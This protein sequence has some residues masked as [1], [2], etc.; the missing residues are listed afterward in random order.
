MGCWNST[1]L[2]SG[3]S[4]EEGDRVVLFPFAS[5]NQLCMIPFRGSYND[6]GCITNIDA[7]PL[8][9]ELINE[10]NA[11]CINESDQAEYLKWSDE[12]L[13]AISR[14]KYLA[15][16]EV[17]GR[18]RTDEERLEYNKAWRT[19]P[20]K[21]IVITRKGNDPFTVETFL[22]QIER[23]HVSYYDMYEEK[24]KGVAFALVREEVWDKMV[25]LLDED[26]ASHNK[27]GMYFESL[28]EIIDKKKTAI[29]NDI[30]EKFSDV[31]EVSEE[32]EEN[33]TASELILNMK[34]MTANNILYGSVNDFT[35]IFH[36]NKKRI[37]SPELFDPYMIAYKEKY[38]LVILTSYL[39]IT[40]ESD[41][42]KGSQFNNHKLMQRAYE[43]FKESISIRD[44]QY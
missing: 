23:G 8:H 18:S 22:K 20:Q 39:R 7:N 44:E 37:T 1:C 32:Q 25:S 41:P 13:V 34:I 36:L 29:L 21:K 24:F 43:I 5:Y 31:D 40:I 33:A 12:E 6:Y 2:L 17:N 15:D 10:L 14:L 3:L 9:D 28:N 19:R 42:M 30:N 38:A 35:K 27:Y 11:M 4:I 16:I 26:E